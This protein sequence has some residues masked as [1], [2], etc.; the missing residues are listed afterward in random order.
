MPESE[1]IMSST[2]IVGKDCPFGPLILIFTWFVSHS[3]HFAA[4]VTQAV[5][6]FLPIP[7]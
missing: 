3:M 6:S 1:Q 2:S 7:G 4:S 5:M